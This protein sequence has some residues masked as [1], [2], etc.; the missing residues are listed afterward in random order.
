MGLTIPGETL[1]GEINTFTTALAAQF[2]LEGC[3]V[4]VAWEPTTTSHTLRIRSPL[5]SGL[6]SVPDTFSQFA[7]GDFFGGDP[8][9]F[10]TVFP[11]CPAN[12]SLKQ[13]LD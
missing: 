13:H 4:G 7:N 9:K 3:R 12:P 10:F 6:Q 8:L 11:S 5:L 1:V 2:L